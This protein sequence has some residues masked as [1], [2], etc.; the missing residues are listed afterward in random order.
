LIPP[1]LARAGALGPA[2]DALGDTLAFEG[3]PEDGEATRD[4]EDGFAD[5][6]DSGPVPAGGN[7]GLGLVVPIGVGMA[8]AGR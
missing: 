2:G 3:R 7:S 4:G 5:G 8:A 1:F 6:L